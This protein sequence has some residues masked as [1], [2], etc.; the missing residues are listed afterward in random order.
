MLIFNEITNINIFNEINN[1]FFHT[2]PLHA[3]IESGNQKIINL[4]LRNKENKEAKDE[5]L[6]NNFTKFSFEFNSSFHKFLF[7][8]QNKSTKNEQ[9]KTLSKNAHN[10]KCCILI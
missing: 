5:I 8:T 9:T 2:T 7:R 3:A 4:I 1:S 10:S 6:K